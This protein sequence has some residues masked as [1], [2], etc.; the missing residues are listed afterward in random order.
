M[1]LEPR[2]SRLGGAS[3]LRSLLQGKKVKI[4]KIKMKKKKVKRRKGKGKKEEKSFF[5][6]LRT[7]KFSAFFKI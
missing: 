2:A 1:R 5:S 3:H 6:K 4:E 7:M